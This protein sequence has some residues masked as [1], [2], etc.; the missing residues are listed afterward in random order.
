M[1]KIKKYKYAG[2]ALLLLSFTACKTPALVQ[3]TENTT[4]PET[5]NGV[6]DTVNVV[7][8]QW[9]DYF[10]DPYLVKLIDTALVNNQE[11][12]ITLQEI[13]IA[14]NEIQAKK[15]EYL[16]FVGLQAGAGAEKVGR[17]TSQGAN[18]ATTPFKGGKENP[19]FLPDFMVGAY[20][21]WEVD[22]WNKLHNAKKA[23]VS[24][25]LATVEGKNFMVT[26]LIAE[27]ANSY[28]ELLAL[29]NQ[30]EILNRNITLQTNAFEIVKLQKQSA[31]VTELAVKRF[32]AQVYSTKSIQYQIQQ[33]IIEAENKIRFLVGGYA[34]NIER[35]AQGFV[36]LTPDLIHAGI[37]SELLANRPDVKQAEL[38]LAAAKLDIK[39]AKA[40]FY[41]SLGLSA[42]VG[43]QAFNAKYLLSTPESLLYSIGG[44][45]TAPLINRKAIKAEYYNANAKQIQAVYNYERTI[46]NAYIEVVNKLSKIS[47][48]ESSFGLQQKEVEA[49]TESIN[50]SNNLFRSARAD[51]MEV[52]LTQRDALE[53]KFELIETKKD[54]MNAFVNIYKALG[55][56]WK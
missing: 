45:L 16:P 11:L 15:G 51:Y 56:G 26:N 35:D 31:K 9:K 10:K 44:D 12:N 48:L 25:Y 3:K 49:L 43:Y 42:G 22:I 23:A 1:N 8:V 47:N 4:L 6:K 28:Y 27:I 18:D 30:L 53:S 46:L 29:D 17:Y 34:G 5:F 38:E 13:E 21:T 40:R 55:G 37:P 33:Q 41:P 52:L 19:E 20:A 39:V 32:E 14:R 7:K 54:Q 36:D 50:I 2:V 24:R